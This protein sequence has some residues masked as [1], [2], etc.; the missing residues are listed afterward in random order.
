MATL[1]DD[2]PYISTAQAARSLGVSVS[3]VKRWVDEGVLPAQKSA[4]G[5]RKLLR[6]EVLALARKGELPTGDVAE[7]ILPPTKRRKEKPDLASYRQALLAPILAGDSAEVRALVRRA[8]RGGLPIETI[9]DQ[10]ISPVME[11]VGH[12][13]ETRQID[14]WQ[15]HRGTLMVAA[16]L[17]DL[18]SEIGR[19]AEQRRPVALG[20]APA[21][22]P[23]LLSSL[24]AQLVLLDAGWQAI[25]LGPNTP[26]QSFV[27]AV[28]ELR[29]KLVWVSASHL[30]DA[31]AFAREYESLHRAAAKHG[32][33]IAVGGRA[34]VESVR[35]KLHYTSHGDGLTH[36]AAFARTLHP[37]PQRPRRGRP[38]QK[39]S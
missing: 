33:A 26:F 6:A 17:F 37:R 12:E 1:R 15:E 25:N 23:Y 36:L 3:T 18:Q 35:A 8:Y 5:H 13:W 22:D 10:M 9:A 34:L 4:G 30:A 32:A 24:L 28:Y 39:S 19:R 20:G 27:K 2:D 21:G 31:S 38:P 14:V 29:P 11:K 16:A 7:L